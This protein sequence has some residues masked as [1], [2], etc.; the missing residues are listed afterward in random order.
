MGLTWAK[1]W[2]TETEGYTD[3]IMWSGAAGHGS[4]GNVG[5]GGAGQ[6][7]KGKG[8]WVLTFRSLLEGVGLHLASGTQEHLSLTHTH[9]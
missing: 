2:G 8:C 6:G 4:S 7:R 3:T 1:I 5:W 9:G